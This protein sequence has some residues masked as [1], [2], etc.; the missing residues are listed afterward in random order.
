MV[1]QVQSKHIAVLAIAV[2][3]SLVG[4]LTYGQ[5]ISGFFYPLKDKL[6]QAPPFS[7]PRRVLGDTVYV[8]N[9]KRTADVRYVRSVLSE[10]N[11]VIDTVVVG[12]L[13]RRGELKTIIHYKKRP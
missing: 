10:A 1:L 2:G 6:R 9:G 12:Q 5:G 3:L 7:Y 11:L 8:L 4:P 13:S